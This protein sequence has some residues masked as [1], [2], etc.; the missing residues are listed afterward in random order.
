M[1]L[2]DIRLLTDPIGNFLM[3]ALGIFMM[4]FTMSMTQFAYWNGYHIT[5]I[6]FG[7]LTL[8]VVLLFAHHIRVIKEAQKLRDEYR[9]RTDPIGWKY[10]RDGVEVT[11]EVIED[12]TKYTFNGKEIVLNDKEFDGIMAVNNMIWQEKQ[13]RKV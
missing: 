9:K 11:G 8:G 5:F 6:V 3:L 2:R 1:N 12:L 4:F 13:L 7:L 10:S